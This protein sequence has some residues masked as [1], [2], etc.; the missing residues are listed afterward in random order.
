MT[1]PRTSTRTTFAI[2]QEPPGSRLRRIRL[3]SPSR[4]A[5]EMRAPWYQRGVV[6]GTFEADN[7]RD[8]H[9]KFTR[10]NPTVEPDRVYLH[11]DVQG[12]KGRRHVRVG[13]LRLC[14]HPR[15]VHAAAP[16]ALEAVKVPTE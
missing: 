4:L 2:V 7:T 15:T 9:E 14:Q 5:I 6:V 13:A 3:L 12:P 10:A 8:A 11:P 1:Q 16:A